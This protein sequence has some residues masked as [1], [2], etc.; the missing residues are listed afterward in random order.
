MNKLLV[1]SLNGLLYC[2]SEVDMYQ[3]YS[4]TKLV[5]DFF[6]THKDRVTQSL[7]SF[8][9]SDAKLE[10]L[11]MVPVLRENLTPRSNVFNHQKISENQF[12]GLIEYLLVEVS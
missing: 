5:Y 6:V 11:L 3:S 7:V 12:G 8:V 10:E 4:N 1:N 2:C 9:L